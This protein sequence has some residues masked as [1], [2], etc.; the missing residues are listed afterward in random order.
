MQLFCFMLIEL[1]ANDLRTQLLGAISKSITN[2]VTV[3]SCLQGPPSF[4]DTLFKSKFSLP[5]TG[6]E[7]YVIKILIDILSTLAVACNVL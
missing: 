3:G 1:L 6:R 2:L 5:A 4:L 7:I